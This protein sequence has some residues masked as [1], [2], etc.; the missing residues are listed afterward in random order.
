MAATIAKIIEWTNV[1]KELFQNEILPLNQP[2]VL[3][4]L[5]KD[6]PAVGKSL[7]S[8]QSIIEYL[9]SYDQGQQVPALIAPPEVKGRFDYQPDLKRFNFERSNQPL[10]KMLNDLFKLTEHPNPPAFSIQGL[11]LDEFLTGFST[12]NKQSLLDEHETARI[13]IGNKTTTR[14]H[15]D[16]VD[17]LACVVTGNR[18]FTL[19]PHEQL[20]N[21]YVGPLLS[22]PAGPPV[23]MVDLA[24]PDFEKYPKFEQALESAQENVLEPGDAIYIP[25]LWWHNVESLDTFNVLVNYLWSKTKPSEVA[26]YQCL[27]HSMLSFPELPEYQRKIWRTVFD[28]YVFQLEGKPGTHLPDDLQDIVTQLSDEQRQKLRNLLGQ[29]LLS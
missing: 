14:T 11:D 8:N 19:F 25:Y 22:T 10:L 4:G 6:W 21:L 18:K 17:N 29:G 9:C 12:K 26:P 3:K 28:H 15:Y 27:M 16:H 24:E 2:A 7:E 1:T 23:S 13:W 5:I 20:V